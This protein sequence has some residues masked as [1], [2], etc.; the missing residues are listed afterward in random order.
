M[1][2]TN[3][4]SA[5]QSSRNMADGP[6]RDWPPV[7]EFHAI[8]TNAFDVFRRSVDAHRAHLRRPVHHLFLRMAYQAETTSVALRNAN[9]WALNLPAFALTRVRLEQTI[10]CS[11][12]IH[13]EEA[14]GLR[15][16]VAHIPIGE[17]RGVKAAI[18]D[19]DLAPHLTDRVSLDTALTSAVNAQQDLD[20]SFDIENDKLSRSW[21]QL[22]LRSMARRRDELVAQKDP[23]PGHRLEAHYVSIYKVASSVVHADGSSLSYRFM[24]VIGVEGET[25]VLMAV[26]SWAPIVAAST[27]HYDILQVSEI[28]GYFGCAP[29]DDLA[30]LSAA[31]RTASDAYM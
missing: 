29:K 13:E 16:F 6:Y 1:S 5:T 24:D 20:P 18:E 28:L 2:A 12:L 25:P 30:A 3:Q 17:Y 4:A 8:S 31:W 7:S 15:P 10:V 23:R 21:T 14:V 26:P 27:A 9:S 22:D 19:P 11:Y